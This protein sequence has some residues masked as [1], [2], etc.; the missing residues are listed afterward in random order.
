MC[1][2]SVV[3]KNDND[4]KQHLYRTPSRTEV[5]IAPTLL[6]TPE[7]P[8]LKWN[9]SYKKSIIYPAFQAPHYTRHGGSP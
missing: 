9:K 2:V 8:E 6:P 3:Y 7:V 1:V 5:Q 4:Q